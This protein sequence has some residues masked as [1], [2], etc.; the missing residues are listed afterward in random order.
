MHLLLVKKAEIH[1]MK[2]KKSVC[3]ILIVALVFTNIDVLGH[4]YLEEGFSIQMV[5]DEFNQLTD[6]EFDH[7]GRM[8]AGLR[9][10]YIYLKDGIEPAQLIIDINEEVNNIGD[11]G[12]MSIALDPN[13]EE[14]GYLYVLFFA[15]L[16]YIR[17]VNS[18]NYDPTFDHYGPSIHRLY[19]YTLDANTDF[20]TVIPDSKKILVGKDLA[21]G[22]P[23]LAN[24]HGSGSLEFGT[25]GSL[26]ISCGDASTYEGPYVGMGP[27]FY[28]EFATQALDDGI[29]KDYE[30]VGS[31]RSQLVDNLNGKILRID[32]ETG[33]G[34]STN[35]FFNTE[36]PRAPRSRVWSMGLR[37]PFRFTVK[38][39]SGSSNI[40]D[41]KPG[42]LM[43]G[44]VGEGT[45]EEFNIADRGGLNFGWPL[46]E[47][48]ERILTYDTLI[49]ENKTAPNPL[50]Y[51]NNCEQ[52]YFT[53]H[54]LIDQ[55]AATI[56]V[57]ENPC[58]TTQ[59]VP[60]S[61]PT[62]RHQLPSMMWPHE[63]KGGIAFVP[64]YNQLGVPYPLSI[65]GQTEIENDGN[66]IGNASI[67]GDFYEGEVW[68]ERFHQGY[69]HT[70]F[71]G[72]WIRFMK[73]N[74][75]NEIEQVFEFYEDEMSIV[76][77]KY[78][79][80]DDCLYLINFDWEK[81]ELHKICYNVNPPPVAVIN[82]D[83]NY[84]PSPLV[85]NF[86]ASDSFDSMGEALTYKWDFGDGAV[87]E[88]SSDAF[89]SHSFATEGSAP[90]AFTVKLT[91]TDEAG[92][93]GRAEKI[94][95]LNNTPPN[96][97]ISSIA[98]GFKYSLAGINILDL[99]ATV[100]DA[101]H[102]EDELTYYW[103]TLL[104][105][106]T[107][108]HPEP[109]VK[110][111]TTTTLLDPVG[112]DGVEYYYEIKL[113][114]ED[115]VGLTG[116]D[117]RFIFPDCESEAFV[118]LASFYAN[119]MGQSV[120]LNWLVLNEV[121]VKNYEVQRS[122]NTGDWVSIETVN[123]NTPS[124]DQSYQSFDYPETPGYLSYRIKINSNTGVSVYSKPVQITF[125]LREP[126]HL[127]PNPS[128]DFVNIEFGNLNDDAQIEI[129]NSNGLLV[130]A[131]SYLS[132]ES[133]GFVTDKV[134][135]SKFSSGMYFVKFSNGTESY[136][137]KLM[138]R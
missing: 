37:N 31:Y 129:Y 86:D 2:I 99:A 127:Y 3:L 89:V 29:I 91:I 54:D 20:S 114:V 15:D 14:N 30:E 133:T 97:Q 55:N 66:F 21:D 85:V 72:G 78:N 88:V 6:I 92:N 125:L 11:L 39:S 43:I 34:L 83:E 111:K 23:Q 98:D 82:C 48:I 62:F 26:F 76:N 69:F 4:K 102:T 128:K 44:D 10:G 120:S 138:V 113:T 112:C 25:D 58:D 95:S 13:F 38:P 90:V 33:D 103:Q 50:F 124:V 104:Y 108:V 84:G 74:D 59:L 57:H 136:V 100:E 41:G 73:I 71:V 87:T 5:T 12:L 118:E 80:H 45:W 28:G 110:E 106:D 131:K 7:Q 75:L 18:P 49:V 81:V 79:P 109:R 94:V 123:A 70:D 24:A 35:P 121:D 47:G 40:E 60:E 130:A 63:D 116:S 16:Y 67:G 137:E 64:D 65:E 27:P 36:N 105:H 119:E 56:V 107:H 134:D 19:R 9:K 68:P 126:I 53:F 46:F 122:V 132:F 32:P 77:L 51:E 8:F 52:E 17:S 42:V 96:V 117:S 93:E 61:I 135:I 22:I 1:F 101:E 115:A